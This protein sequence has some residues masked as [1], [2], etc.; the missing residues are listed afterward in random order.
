M[1]EALQGT[2]YFVLIEGKLSGDQGVFSLSLDC[3][4]S[5]GAEHCGNSVDDDGDSLI[6]C[7]D[8]DC[9]FVSVCL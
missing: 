4:G 8:S 7:D 5:P 1:F 3:S 6:D 9:D 2:D